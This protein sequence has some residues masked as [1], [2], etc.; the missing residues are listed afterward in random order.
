MSSNSNKSKTRKIQLTLDNITIDVQQV[1]IKYDDNYYG[2]IDFNNQ[3]IV[4]VNFNVLIDTISD[5]CNSKNKD[6]YARSDI[7]N[8]G[9]ISSQPI[10]SNTISININIPFYLDVYSGTWIP[11]SCFAMEY[12]DHEYERYFQH[13]NGYGHPIEINYYY[14]EPFL[15]D[16]SQACKQ[17][18]YYKNRMVDSSTFNIGS[19]TGNLMYMIASYYLFGWQ[20]K[21]PNKH[22]FNLTNNFSLKVSN[23]KIIGDRYNCKD[24]T[25]LNYILQTNSV[26]FPSYLMMKRDK[27]NLNEIFRAH[28]YL[29]QMIGELNYND[30][31]LKSIYECV[32][33]L[34]KI[35]NTNKYCGFD[36]SEMVGSFI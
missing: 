30:S 11:F 20:N 35:Q 8:I 13:S 26:E 19:K 12:V 15:N 31:Q 16:N 28:H 32:A 9:A 23:T 5:K 1:P 29:L 33:F 24:V 7:S 17:H 25:T 21:M 22:N 2:V 3:N 27:D 36:E 10:E 4:L 18:K 14:P 34:N 6:N